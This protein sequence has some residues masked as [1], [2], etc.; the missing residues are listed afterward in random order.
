MDKLLK[1][2]LNDISDF[3]WFYYLFQFFT[4]Y[5]KSEF[6]NCFSNLKLTSTALNFKLD[7][8]HLSA[9]HSINFSSSSNAKSSLVT[10]DF[11]M[12][13]CSVSSQAVQ[14]R[15]KRYTTLSS[16]SEP[17]RINRSLTLST[18]AISQDRLAA[19]KL[20]GNLKNKVSA[21]HLH[22]HR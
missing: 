6:G 16:Q 17:L 19:V 18:P 10:T 20:N 4:V 12:S 8:L 3:I 2:I 7:S 15:Q 13:Q 5:I 9:T 1:L 14:T 22:R 11:V 21:T